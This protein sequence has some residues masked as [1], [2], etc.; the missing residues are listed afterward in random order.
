MTCS[1]SALLTQYEADY[2]R[3][4]R[5]GSEIRCQYNFGTKVA[6]NWVAG[7]SGALYCP[8]MTITSYSLTDT[9]GIFFL[10]MDLGGFVDSQGQG[11]VYLGFV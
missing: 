7:K 9:D 10:N 4:F 2:F 11:E 6:G 8:S 5:E 3:K 1:V